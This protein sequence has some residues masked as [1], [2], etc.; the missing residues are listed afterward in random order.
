M[1]ERLLTRPPEITA[2]YLLSENRRPEAL[3]RMH[4]YME[5]KANG[6][7]TDGVFCS[8]ARLLGTLALGTYK[9]RPTRDIAVAGRIN[10]FK[11]IA[12]HDGS[13]QIVVAGHYDSTTQ[14]ADQPV[15]GC[16]GLMALAKMNL[17]E[18]FAGDT[19]QGYVKKYVKSPNVTFQTMM[20]SA[21]LTQYTDKPVLAVLWDHITYQITPIA[22]FDRANKRYK[23][24]ISQEELFKAPEKFKNINIMDIIEPLNLS[25]L[26][27]EELTQLLKNNEQLVEKVTENQVFMSSQKIQ[28]PP[29]VMVTTSVVP[30]TARYPSLAMP[31]MVFKVLL[32][33]IKEGGGSGV[34]IEPEYTEFAISQAHYPISHAVTAES[35]Q[36]FFDTNK[37]L[38]ETP[39]IR[40]SLQI[41]EE[42]KK[43]PWFN[44][45]EEKKNG[46]II[47]AG[48]KSG[49]TEEINEI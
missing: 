31:N 44:E 48:V 43:R 42:F 27:S 26:I 5:A 3:T 33:F 15:D 6:Q 8:D 29:L 49:V 2:N 28:D 34:S 41:A 10:P 7:L 24:I 25:G 30:F 38:I 32:P 22:L 11:Y 13:K 21:K 45:W 35:G 47:I 1:A 17:M 46:K 19:A 16:G 37:I 4:E 18:N 39:D 9:I 20:S 36:A 40:T 12:T 14:K 23:G